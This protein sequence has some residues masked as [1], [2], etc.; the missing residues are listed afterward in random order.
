[1]SGF[2]NI[3]NIKGDTNCCKIAAVCSYGS[4]MVIMKAVTKY[5]PNEPITHKYTRAWYILK[6]MKESSD[7]SVQTIVD[8]SYI[9]SNIVH[10][11][12]RYD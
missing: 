2:N 11:G 12:C 5:I 4:E 6:K 7:Q 9:H 1:M 10:N 3:F 8:D